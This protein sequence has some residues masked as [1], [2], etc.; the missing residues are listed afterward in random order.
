M[1]TGPGL[2][3]SRDHETSSGEL[4][5]WHGIRVNTDSQEYGRLNYALL[6]GQEQLVTKDGG[7]RVVELRVFRVQVQV[8]GVNR[9]A[10]LTHNGDMV[11]ALTSTNRIPS[12]NEGGDKGSS[13]SL[14]QKTGPP[15][16]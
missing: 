10:L 2:D 5:S 12:S 3:H 13:S 14:R 4:N 8:W 15:Q 9:E 6:F 1:G 16:A 7:V 11:W